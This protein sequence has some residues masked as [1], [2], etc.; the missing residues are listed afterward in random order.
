[1]TDDA[2]RF[3]KQAQEC[4]EQAE[5]SLSPLDRETWLRVA[6]EWMKLAQSVDDN[7]RK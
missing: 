6:A 4:V 7:A 1:M 3:R 5:R 2:A